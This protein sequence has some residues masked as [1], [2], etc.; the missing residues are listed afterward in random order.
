MMDIREIKLKLQR[1]VPRIHNLPKVIYI[2]WLGYEW[3]I[4]KK[5]K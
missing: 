3:F 1:L 4:E 2:S 5:I